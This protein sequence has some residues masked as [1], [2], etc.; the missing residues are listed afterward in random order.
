MEVEDSNCNIF[1]DGDPVVLVKYL[2]VRGS[3]INRKL[4]A[5]VKNTKPT[6][7]KEEV[8]SRTDGCH[9]IFRTEFIKKV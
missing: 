5:P 7:N 9:I 1:A 8:D 2:K 6:D 3:S 4:G